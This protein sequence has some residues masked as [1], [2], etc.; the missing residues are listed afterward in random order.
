GINGFYR[1]F[2]PC[3]LRSFPANACAI[4]AFESTMRFLKNKNL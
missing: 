4:V 1:G 3:I 2:I